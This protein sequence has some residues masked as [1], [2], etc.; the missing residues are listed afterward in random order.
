MSSSVK[1]APEGQHTIQATSVVRI[2]V[3]KATNG[4]ELMEGE[5]ELFAGTM[6]KFIGEKEK[7][8]RWQLFFKA[9]KK[10]LIPTCLKF[11]C[12]EAHGENGCY[13][14]VTNK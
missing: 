3:T 10:A 14:L 11:K 2:A 12:A 4:I 7:L 5:L 8:A 6:D 9:L 1:V 13:I